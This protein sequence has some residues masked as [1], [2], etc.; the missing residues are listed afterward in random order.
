MKLMLKEFPR[1][2]RQRAAHSHSSRHLHG[3]RVN[4]GDNFCWLQTRQSYS[5]FPG[6]TFF[7]PLFSNWELSCLMSQVP[8]DPIQQFISLETCFM[9]STH[10]SSN[11]RRGNNAF[12]L[13][14]PIHYTFADLFIEN[15][16]LYGIVQSTELW[17]MS[18]IIRFSPLIL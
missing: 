4:E 14:F 2:E 10:S 7:I 17:T 5:S 16:S 3:G 9:K 6:P 11:G 13:I 12:A 18:A 8:G 15:T 1:A